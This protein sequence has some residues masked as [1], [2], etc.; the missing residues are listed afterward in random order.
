M[1]LQRIP[2]YENKGRLVALS[3]RPVSGLILRQMIRCKRECNA[4]EYF[5]FFASFAAASHGRI[6]IVSR[7]L[8]KGKTHEK[9]FREIYLV[10]AF[11]GSSFE[12]GWYEFEAVGGLRHHMRL[13]LASE[14]TKHEQHFS[15]SN[16]AEP[17]KL[18]NTLHFRW[19]AVFK[20]R[21]KKKPFSLHCAQQ[22]TAKYH[23]PCN[24]FRVIIKICFDMII[25][26]PKANVNC[27][28]L[29]MRK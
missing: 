18:N 20:E 6:S 4:W 29:E 24:N 28:P 1:Y 9:V 12:D 13:Y 2:S 17:M 8:L 10:L 5:T 3:R 26:G 16:N 27:R 21:H 23:A 7:W 14:R 22:S 25:V 11:F 19:N 15:T